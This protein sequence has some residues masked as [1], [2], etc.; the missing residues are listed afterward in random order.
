MADEK[1]PAAAQDEPQAQPA[2]AAE[3]EREMAF[4]ETIPGGKYMQGGQLVNAWG[5]PIDAKGNVKK[6]E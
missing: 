6:G 4:N 5:E 2:A 3:P 1:K